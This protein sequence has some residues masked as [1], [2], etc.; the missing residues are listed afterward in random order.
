[1]ATCGGFAAD[2]KR[3][4]VANNGFCHVGSE[5]GKL[6]PSMPPEP[7]FQWRR[8]RPWTWWLQVPLPTGL[9]RC[10]LPYWHGEGGPSSQVDRRFVFE[11]YKFPYHH[12]VRCML[13]VKDELRKVDKWLKVTK[14]LCCR[15]SGSQLKLSF[16]IRTS[17]PRGLIV[18]AGRKMMTSASDFFSM[19]LKH[20]YLQATFSLGSGQ[21][22]I[23]YNY[24]T[25]SD[26]QW[27][28]VRFVR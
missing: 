9:P 25:I 12:K 28:L 14:W 13:L 4:A 17:Y 16:R 22:T 18:W 11:V 27:H 20:G 6:C 3:E 1:M 8:M 24:T 10:L 26:G 2:N 7:V 19:G 5:P 15:I 23:A 21:T